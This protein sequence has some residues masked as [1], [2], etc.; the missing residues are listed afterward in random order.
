MVLYPGNQE[1]PGKSSFSLRCTVENGY[2][3][4]A[5]GIIG[6]ND[7]F[8][9]SCRNQS[10]TNRSCD[11]IDLI[12]RTVLLP[13]GHRFDEMEALRVPGDRQNRIAAISPS[14]YPCSRFIILGNT[15]L[16]PIDVR[17]KL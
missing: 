17:I 4:V 7:E 6:V 12:S 10:L 1:D 5:P 11:I 16:P 9:F 13:F 8:A 3:S 15:L 2:D 14:S